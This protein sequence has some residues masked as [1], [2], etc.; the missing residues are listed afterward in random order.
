LSDR[1]KTDNRELHRRIGLAALDRRYVSVDVLTDAMVAA[2][3]NQLATPAEIWVQTGRLDRTELAEILNRV[4]PGGKLLADLAVNAERGDGDAPFLAAEAPGDAS[5][6]A[7][8]SYTLADVLKTHGFSV[9]ERISQASADVAQDTSTAAFS[10]GDRYL[11]G[12]ELGR[13]GVGRVIKSFDRFLGRTI[14]MKLPLYWPTV[15]EEVDKFIEEAQATGQLEHPNIVPIYDIGSLPGGQLYYTMKRVRNQSLRDVIDS[16]LTGD[17]E[18]TSEYGNTR[19]LS[20]FLQ[21]CQAIHY[22]H[23][24]GVIH[25]DLKPDNIMLGDYGEVHVMD[26][27]LA[28]ILDRTDDRPQAV[29]TDR[30]LLGG[31]RL[32]AG[33]TL[34][35]PAYMPPEQAQGRLDEVDERSDIYSLGVILYE[36]ITLRQPSTRSTVM[37]TLM[38]VI[39]EPIIPPSQASPER[40]VNADMDRIIMRALEKDPAKRWRTAK[41]F[42][43]TVEK[44]LDGRNEREAER[45]LLEGESFVRLYEQAKGE[46]IRIDKKVDEAKSRLHDWEP[47]EVKRGLWELEDRR[48]ETSSR[49]VRTFGDAIR[50]LTKALAYVPDNAPAKQSLARLYWSRYE[51]A[52]RE[53]N[54]R[55]QL[56]YLSLLRQYDD[57]SYLARIH[58][59]APV[60]I[61]TR[62]KKVSVFLYTYK[63]VDRTLILSDAQYLGKAP[64]AEFFLRRGSYHLRLKQPGTPVVQFP[65]FIQRPDPVGVTFEI[66]SPD[67][68]REGYVFV[69]RGTSVIG[70]DPEAVDPLPYARLVVPSY[71]IKQFPVTFREYLAFLDDLARTHPDEA[72][73]RAPRTRD[74]DGQLAIRNAEGRFVPSEVLIEGPMRSIYPRGMGHEYDL[75]V[76][77]VRYEDALAFAAWLSKR[78][79][80]TYR[81]PTEQEWE[82]AARGADGRVYPWG[83]F[84]DATF[85]KMSHSRDMPSQP[86]PVGTFAYDRSP[87]DVHDL[88]GGVRDFVDSDEGD[89]SQTIIRGGY[90]AADARSCRA[91]SRRRILKSARLAN[92]GFRLVYEVP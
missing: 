8:R 82:R 33:Q 45:H 70:G 42:H 43:D 17:P 30:S 14:A 3:S 66:P 40:N 38:A 27:G 7:S 81:L 32:E 16:L 63:D 60:S 46:L 41:E 12:G 69:P 10:G 50:D 39:T 86:E 88:A 52:E 87:F 6:D 68:F 78:D 85:C 48:R 18:V 62:P 75:P 76:V 72:E 54:E 4:A 24:R 28:R 34:G 21:V 23:A 29:V 36:I 2:G 58:D 89:Y 64:I 44:F 71:F 77:A 20:I 57:G 73:D 92:I 47:I 49:M 55:D 19:L 35:T 53:D 74:A 91:A 79:G 65:L 56:Y 25:R 5:G 13:G 84:F 15:P 67:A 37:E 80:L 90:W 31:D 22:A 83:N 61:Y 51:L 59:N 11:L 1:V 9:P 26:W